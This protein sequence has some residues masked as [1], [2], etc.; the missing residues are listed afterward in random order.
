MQVHVVFSHGLESGPS[1]TKIDALA[2][3]ARRRGAHVD[4]L[5]YRAD[6]VPAD[7]IERLVA[8]ATRL[9]RPVVLVGSSLGAYVSLV[10]CERVRP[11][12]LFLMAPAVYLDKAGLEVKT[13]PGL[14]ADVSVV[15]G[16][17]DDV[18][19]SANVLRFADAHRAELTL[20]DAG[21]RLNDQRSLATLCERFDALLVRV[22][23]G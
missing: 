15:H 20:V 16:W 22:R 6:R 17:G 7:R 8:H 1:G 18:V 21:H 5:D 10:A 19:P 4:A 2:E 23:P 12:A 11:A 13:F 9:P 3:V 14:P